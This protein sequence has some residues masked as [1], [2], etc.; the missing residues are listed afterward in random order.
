MFLFDFANTA[1]LE[2]W[3]TLEFE[4]IMNAAVAAILDSVWHLLY[5]HNSP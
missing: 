2:H 1:A 3:S 5:L 4:L